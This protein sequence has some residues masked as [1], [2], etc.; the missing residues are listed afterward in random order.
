M[1][2]LAILNAFRLKLTDL[3]S[4]RVL[5]LALVILPI[6]LGLMAGTANTANRQPDIVLAVI[7][8]D[9]SDVSRQLVRSLSDQGWIV[10]EGTPQ[11]TQRW[12]VKRTVEGILTIKAG[13]AQSIDE[14]EENYLTYA[15][16]EG[17]LIT[18]MVYE[19]IAS[20]VLPANTRL[21]LLGQIADRHEDLKL[22]V[23]DDLEL[24]FDQAAEAF[25]QDQARLDVLYHGAP[26]NGPTLT[27]LVSDYSMEVFFL[28]IYAILGTLALSG[29]AIRR[30][31]AATPNGLLADYTLSILSLLTLGL[32]QILLYTTAMSL[33]MKTPIRLSELSILAVCLLLMLGLGQILS[34]IHESIRLYVSL[35]ILLALAVASGCFFQLSHDLMT[36]IGQYLPQGWALAALLGYPVLP[37]S[38]PIIIALFLL[39]IGY[40]AAVR[41]TRLAR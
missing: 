11:E 40:A 22:P 18:S 8:Q 34:L 15:P 31:L 13:Y 29:R 20:E 23:P 24:R 26:E 14:L 19:A 17:S 38:I 33:W 32:V 36:R 16:A 39:A 28:S 35:L 4:S 7:D 41:R 25:A 3:L 12:L 5:L 1:S 6:L 9:Q 10:R 30:R 37:S 21:L 27:Y 2:G